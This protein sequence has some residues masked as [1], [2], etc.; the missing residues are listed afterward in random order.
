MSFH[1]FNPFLIASANEKSAR[2]SLKSAV[3]RYNRNKTLNDD[4]KRYGAGL[5]DLYNIFDLFKQD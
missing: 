3:E 5:T 2:G 4:A 1:V